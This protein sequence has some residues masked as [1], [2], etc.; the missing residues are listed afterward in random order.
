MK[1]DGQTERQIYTDSHTQT[2]KHRHTDTDKQ[3]DRHRKTPEG[4]DRRKTDFER[5]TIP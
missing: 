4:T 5:I 2:D 1:T 3:T